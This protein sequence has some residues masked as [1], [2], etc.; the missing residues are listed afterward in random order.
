MPEEITPSKIINWAKYEASFEE[1]EQVSKTLYGCYI[2]RRKNYYPE[3]HKQNKK[4]K[5]RLEI[6]KLKKELGNSYK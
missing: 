2:N 5:L 6:K 3:V 4:K 1:L